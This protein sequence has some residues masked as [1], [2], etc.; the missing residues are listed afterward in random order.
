M[1]LGGAISKNDNDTN[2]LIPDEIGNCS[3]IAHKKGKTKIC[4]DPNVLIGINKSLPDN[5]KIKLDD[6]IDDDGQN[7]QNDKQSEQII[8]NAKKYTKCEDERCV[9]NSRLL[10]HDY[11]TIKLINNNLK[12]NFKIDGPT[13]VSLLSNYNI[14]KTLQQ[15]ATHFKDFFAYNFNMVDYERQGDTLHTIDIM[16]LYDRG[17]RTC[18]CVINSDVYSG[19]GKHWMA[20]FVD[21]R[22]LSQW[23]VEFFN[24]S[25]NRPVESFARWLTKTKNRLEDIIE[26]HNLKNIK[27]DIIKVTGIM[28]QYSK[29]ECGVYSLYYIWARLNGKK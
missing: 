16:D 22:N 24:S 2:E 5:Y 27:V 18:A 28:H 19:R 6:F 13:D 15:W 14:D 7:K 29:T 1:K 11:E 17:Y 3:L 25:G 8:E 12:T 10:S 9:L 26:K 4:S 20:L 21:M 23:T